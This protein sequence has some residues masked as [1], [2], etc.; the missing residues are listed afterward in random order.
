MKFENVRVYGL[1]ESIIASGYPMSINTSECFA[2]NE[3]AA[4]L[5]HAKNGS[6]HDCFL[7]GIIVQVDIIAPQYFWLQ[8]DRYHFCDVVSSQSTMHR[9]TKMDIEKQCNDYVF[10][11]TIDMLKKYI[12]LYNNFTDEYCR[13]ITGVSLTKEK[14]FQ[15]IVS[16]I[17][18]GLML[19][20]RITSN[21]LQE[22]SIHL[23]RE[24]HKL[25]EWNKYIEW[26][27]SL[28]M[29]RELVINPI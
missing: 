5:G 1:E 8:W 2:N 22:K 16:N 3:R 11:V 12:D 28:P 18:E 24:H 9:I 15:T 29:F 4:K 23:Q 7:K 20:K 21:Y 14:V 6:G 25:E 19:T 27:K 26:Q 17:P 13:E 10:D